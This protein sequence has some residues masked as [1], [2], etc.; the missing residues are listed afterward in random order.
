MLLHLTQRGVKRN[1]CYYDI[2]ICSNDFLVRKCRCVVSCLSSTQ[3]VSRHFFI[4]FWIA[5]SFGTGEFTYFSDI[6]FR[7]YCQRFHEQPGFHW[8]FHNCNTFGIR[9]DHC[10]QDG[11]LSGSSSDSCSNVSACASVK[12]A[13]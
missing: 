1:N 8:K 5:C 12:S 10:Y 3:R 4:M 6:L 7:E 11:I 2:L 13:S 9:K